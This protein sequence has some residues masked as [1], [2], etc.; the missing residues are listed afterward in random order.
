[1]FI[2]YSD[3]SGERDAV[4]AALQAKVASL[5]AA[6]LEHENANDT[7]I[8]MNARNSNTNGLAS[9]SSSSIM[10]SSSHGRPS[11]LDMS[12]KSTSSGRSNVSNGI[13][14]SSSD[15]MNWSSASE[16]GA[17]MRAVSPP[18]AAASALPSS[19]ITTNDGSKLQDQSTT[20][21]QSTPS[22]SRSPLLQP[23]YY[24]HTI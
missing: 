15:D 9:S 2:I 23:G 4:M 17:S 21:S 14:R 16:L 11:S 8:L 5:T 10:S 19:N 24:L 20:L 22:S 7:S 18:A 12:N 13:N 6:L 1:L 3:L